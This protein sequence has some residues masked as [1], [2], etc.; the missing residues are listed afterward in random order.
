MPTPPLVPPVPVP[1]IQSQQAGA[2]PWGEQVASAAWIEEKQSRA[3]Q[4]TITGDTIIYR[5]L[6][7]GTPSQ[8]T[9]DPNMGSVKIGYP[10]PE[11]RNYFITGITYA[12]HTFGVD[13]EQTSLER[14]TTARDNKPTTLVTITYQLVPP[15][16]LWQEETDTVLITRLEWYD[17]DGNS[18]M[19]TREGIPLLIPQTIYKRV[20]RITFLTRDEKVT[21]E[22]LEGK[23][24]GQVWLKRPAGFWLMEKIR[25][26]LLY[27][28]PTG[29]DKC[30]YEVM[31]Q[32][33]GDPDR[34]HQ[35]WFPMTDA[36]GVPISSYDPA[37]PEL[38]FTRRTLYKLD[39][40]DWDKVVPL[41]GIPTESPNWENNP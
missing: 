17:R 2:L 14:P 28:N 32:A 9:K 40:Q 31:L 41:W 34:L 16:G 10:H 5:F 4:R 8:V 22:N 15:P 13:T 26:R 36:S 12:P 3:S 6:V 38:A 18:L 23:R 27:G 37:H 1:V 35:W 33:R 30:A 24:N 11:K 39:E 7:V 19:N 21:I 25:C 20:Y 29:D